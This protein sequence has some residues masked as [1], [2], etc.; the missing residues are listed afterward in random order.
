MVVIPVSPSRTELR[1]TQGSPNVNAEP[2]IRPSGRRIVARRNEATMEATME[3]RDAARRD[4]DVSAEPG[5]PL[6]LHRDFPASK[7]RPAKGD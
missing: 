6:L 5:L 2:L 1:L 4:L 7:K 3:G